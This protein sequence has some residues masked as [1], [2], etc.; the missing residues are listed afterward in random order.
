M[1][2]NSESLR[3]LLVEYFRQYIDLREYPSR[4]TFSI[5]GV[6]IDIDITD[7]YDY[8]AILANRI[9]F[10]CHGPEPQLV[11]KTS[12]TVEIEDPNLFDKL[13]DFM[14]SGKVKWYDAVMSDGGAFR[15]YS[16]GTKLKAN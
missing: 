5:S 16:Y 3:V 2:V 1:E 13:D 11:V 8:I 4:T 15:F 9:V 10:R 7:I 12:E 14:A 6:R